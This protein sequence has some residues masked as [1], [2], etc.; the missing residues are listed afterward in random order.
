[1][2]EAYSVPV[3][4]VTDTIVLPGMVVP[5][6]LD[7]AARAAIDAAQASESGQLLIAPRLEDRYPSHG[8]IA[9][10]VQVG[11]IAGGGTAAVV[12]GERRAQIGAGTSGPGAALWVQATPVP[13]AAITDEIKTL[14][15]EYKKLLLAMLQRREAWEIID[16]V[17]RL[18]DPSALADTSGYASYLTSAQKRQLLETVDVAERLRVLIDWTS[19]HLAEVE[20]SDKI[21]EDV[22]EGM[23]KTQKEFLLRQQLAAIRKELGEGEP[24]GSDE[25]RA[26]VEAADLPEKVRE[27][28]LREVGKLERAS[29]QSPESGWIRTW[30]DT[31]LELPWN[32]RTD[33]STDLKAARDILD[34]DHHGLDDVKDRI[35]EYLAVRTRRTQRGLQV[36]GGRGSG[37]V[38]VLAGPPGVGKTSLGESVAR[39]LGRKFV[40]VALGGVRDEAEIRGHRRT[41]V[42][43]LPGRIVRAIGE[44]GSMNPVV[45]LDEIDKV[46]SDYR[47]DPSAAL[48]EVLDPA[49]NHTFRDHYL[50]LDLDLSDVVFLATANVVENIPSALLDRMELVTIDGYTEDDKV[51]I[52]RD[53][54]LPR[55]RERAALTEDEVTVTDAALRKIAADYTREPGVRQF[56]R[57]LAKALRKVTTKL[58][59]QPGPVTID[60]PDLVAYLGRP[61]F[62]PESAERTAVPGV[63]TGLAVTGLGGD[64]LYIEAGATDGEPGLQLTG[65]LGDVMKE[66]AQIA[67]S[68]VRS[69]AA[70]LGVDPKALD[71][72]IHVHV[73]AGAV[74]K[75]GPSA[76]VTMVTALVSMATGRQVR[77]DVGMTGEV[78]LNGRVLPIG[79]VKQKL[80]AAQRA[81]LSTVF[82][83][84]RNEPDLDDVPAEV[85]EAVTVTPMTDV[86]DIVAQALEPV[87]APAAAAA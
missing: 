37:A 75:D 68:Y 82:I 18:T 13:D 40:R 16:Y 35:V 57:L 49:Q 61:R 17:N 56:E 67:L 65:Q 3:L 26:R 24:D 53:Y 70:A 21:A 69:H 33:D 79:G 74:P 4:F 32:V 76:G 28:A 30:L 2:A 6:A 34:A 81:G 77:S 54:L 45:L 1:M 15:A 71:R 55:Q 44:A 73:P 64:V 25:Y 60:E 52:A 59:E 78:T 72:R 29:D 47:G 50:D 5:I 31:V 84:S 63:A 36:V 46:G 62:T 11:R 38:M 19:S 42:G 39:A 58:A 87:T 22:R 14:A 12:R 27:T 41:Y 85:L 20:V 7:D 80:L 23:E 48:L 43:A 66:S 86:A 83:P 8:V 51:A 9:K 10:I